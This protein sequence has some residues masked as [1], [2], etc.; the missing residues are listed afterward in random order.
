VVSS[1]PRLH[2]TPGKEPVHILQESG[3]A[4]G[5]V[6]TVGKSRPHR[7]SIPDRPARSQSLYR[8]SY[9]AHQYRCNNL[10]SRSGVIHFVSFFSTITLQGGFINRR[11]VQCG[12]ANLTHPNILNV[13]YNKAVKFNVEDRYGK[14]LSLRWISRCAFLQQLYEL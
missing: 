14:E 2:F 13:I 4:L 8:L 10:K 12:S 11:T 9:P 6:W 5:P 3:W 7:D 1:T